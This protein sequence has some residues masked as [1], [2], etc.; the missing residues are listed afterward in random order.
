MIVRVA[1]ELVPGELEVLRTMRP[2]VPAVEGGRQ[3]AHQQE[4]LEVA[5]QP[6]EVGSKRGEQLVQLAVFRRPK[7]NLAIRFVDRH[8]AGEGVEGFGELSP[9]ES[10]KVVRQHA[11]VGE[12]GPLRRLEAI[13]GPV[14]VVVGVGARW[15]IGPKEG[16]HADQFGGDV[17]FGDVVAVHLS[18]CAWED[19]DDGENLVCFLVVMVEM[20]AE[21]FLIFLFRLVTVTVQVCRCAHVSVRKKNCK[22][23]FKSIVNK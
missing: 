10:L 6:V 14:V 22:K 2:D 17:L 3:Q 18:S 23:N 21:D 12:D 1:L 4:E 9:E 20:L 5:L 19:T 7:Q 16:V 8:Q 11:P 15:A 13:G